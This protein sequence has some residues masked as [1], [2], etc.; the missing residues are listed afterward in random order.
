MAVLA[1]EVGS[2]HKSLVA[3]FMWEMFFIGSAGIWHF[4]QLYT[5]AQSV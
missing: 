2:L 4:L 5:D 3:V 1:F